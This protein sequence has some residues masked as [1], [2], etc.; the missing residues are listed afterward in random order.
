MFLLSLPFNKNPIRSYR[1][2]FYVSHRYSICC[3]KLEDFT[4]HEL[5]AVLRLRSE[6]FVLEQTFIYQDMD[7]KDQEAVHILGLKDQELV[8]YSRIF[9]RGNY[10]KEAIIGRVVVTKKERKQTYGHDLV[11]DSIAAIESHF[12]YRIVKTSAQ[13]HLQ[14]FYE[15]HGFTTEGTSYLEDGIPRIGMLKS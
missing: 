11:N 4:L 9:N 15:S 14:K 8:A 1:H 2:L 12:N 7:A 10:F 3:K 13:L 6:V 5:Y